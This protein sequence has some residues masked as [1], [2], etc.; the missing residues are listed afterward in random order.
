MS[1]EDRIKCFED[2]QARCNEACLAAGTA[3]AVRD[4]RVYPAGFVSNR[5]YRVWESEISVMEGSSLAAARENLP[6]GKVAVLNF[7]NP[8]YPGGGVAQGTMGQE[9]CLCL[10]SALYPCL[11]GDGVFEEFYLH[12]R[13]KTDYD[14]SDRLIYSPGV[15][16]FK[17]DSPVPRL[18][19]EADWFRV[20]VITC[21]AP[22][23]AKRRYVNQT[24]LR[25]LFKSR[26]R[27]ILEAAI[28]NEIEVLILGAFGCGSFGNPPELV[29]SAFREV[30]SQRRYS[31][32]FAK[33]VFAVRS[34]VG[35]DPYTVCPNIAAFQQAFCGESTE[36]QKLRYVGGPQNA[37]G[38]QDVTMPGGRIRYRGSESRAYHAWREKNPYFGKR[39]S[40]LGDS[41]STLEGF[42][43]R[44]NPVF[45]DVACREK[46]GVWEMG[47]TWWGKT[48]EFFG[49]ELLVNDSWSGCR[50]ARPQGSAEAFPCGCSEK[51]T[52]RLHVGDVMPD[53]IL[54]YMG[55][56][57]WGVGVIPEPDGIDEGDTCFSLAYARMLAQ[58]RR[59]YPDAQ[60]WCCT[61]AATC[62]ESNPKFKFPESFG[63]VNIR[64]YNHQIVNAAMAAGC[65]V[66]DLYSQEIPFDTLDGTHPTVRG[67]DTLAMLMVRQMADEDGGDLLDCELTHAPHN[68]VCRRCGRPMPECRREN[69]LRMKRLGTGEILFGS[70]WQVTLGR[71]RESGIVLD[72]PYV[73]RSQATFTC[74]EGQ[75]YLRDNGTRNGTALNGSRLDADREYRIHPGDRITFAQKEEVQV[76]P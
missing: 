22:Y 31:T 14:F 73:A 29:A 19:E 49:G 75:W 51:R 9:E 44:G 1:R 66:A 37:P 42:H 59:N 41:I 2:T 55:M 23:L 50:V 15:T 74:R 40:V 76:L 53:V 24:V 38:A 64:E 67:M 54:V 7:A 12:H 70:G 52:G 68:G 28:E 45:Y 20:D 6:L 26:I 25:N 21:A 63:G 27:N 35:G 5:L 13:T 72:N 65:C 57:D 30:L 39:F 56:N 62:M 43:P 69:S 33:V 18:M 36:L 3:R 32:A 34:S 47:D 16:V 11:N 61:L 8:H 4:S 71:S 17:D 48:I 46:S 10:S 58:L 60:I